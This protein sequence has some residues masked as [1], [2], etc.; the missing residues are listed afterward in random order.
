MIGHTFSTGLCQDAPL[1]R[2]RRWPACAC[3]HADRCNAQAG[4]DRRKNL[5]C[6]C[7]LRFQNFSPPCPP[8]NSL[9]D[10]GGR[11]GGLDSDTAPDSNNY[12]SVSGFFNVAAEILA[13]NSSAPGLCQGL[14]RLV[15]TCLPPASASVAPASGRQGQTDAGHGKKSL[16]K[17]PEDVF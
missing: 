4:A 16:C 14:Y 15:L 17:F 12:F 9:P 7:T 6:S 1:A 3:T 13:K 10:R 2:M 8:I 5:K 11:G